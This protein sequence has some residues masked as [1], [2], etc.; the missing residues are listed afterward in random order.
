[1]YNRLLRQPGAGIRLIWRFLA[2]NRNYAK[3]IIILLVLALAIWVDIPH[4]TGIEIGTFKRSLQPVLGLDLRGGMRVLLEAQ[5]E[6]LAN[7]NTQSMEDTRQILENRSNGLGVSEVLFQVAGN[8]RIVGEFPGYTNSDE[9]VKVLKSTGLLEF[10]DLGDTPMQEG[11]VIKTD[12]GQDQN[13]A[14]EPTSTSTPLAQE[15][16]TSDIAGSQP[17]ATPQTPEEKVWHTIMT[18][19]DL[20]AVAATVDQLGKFV[21]DFQLNPD[22]QKVFADYTT[23]NVGKYLAIVLDKTVISSPVVNTPITEGQGQIS[24]SFTYETSN[25]LAIQLRY[26]SLPIGLDVLQT[27]VIGPTLG[28]DSLNKSLLAGAIGFMIVMLFMVLYYRLPGA[29]AVISILIYGAIT[30]ALYKLIPV[31]LTLP[32]IAGFLLSTGGALD[33]NILIFERLKEELRNGRNLRQSLDLGWKRAWPSIRD[34]NL[35]TIITS[36]I[37]IIFGSAYGASIVKGFA[38]TLI[39]GVIVSLLAAYFITRTFLNIVVEYTNP[40]DHEKW[41]GA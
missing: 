39:L 22:G 25:A 36:I 28:Q 29:V 5:K 11:T 24:G 2:V 13:V 41:F 14:T 10:V 18:G 4:A 40:T 32:G 12:Y 26:G 35:A 3:L 34:S 27:E 19:K 17:T 23:N 20:K 37:L 31:T 38:V 33:A 16:P 8:N 21:V 15:T 6:S 30:F 1:V 7:V 9:A